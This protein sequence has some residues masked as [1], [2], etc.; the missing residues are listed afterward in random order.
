MGVSGK[1]RA[2][3][4]PIEAASGA[5][6]PMEA[7]EVPAHPEHA[8]AA[9][10]ADTDLPMSNRVGRPRGIPKTGG[11]KKGVKNR[12]TRQ[13]KELAL[14]YGKR[15]FTRLAKLLKSDDDKIVLAA[16]REI[17]D[18]AYGRPQVFNEITGPGGSPL[19]KT[20]ADE[21]DIARRVA[22]LLTRGLAPK[23]VP[24]MPDIDDGK[25]APPH[26]AGQT[27]SA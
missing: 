6:K 26:R 27:Q 16:S 8:S 1:Q 5:S 12:I 21:R 7:S 11:R 14:P 20:P 19:I 22:F 13:I 9:S 4:R 10:Q 3:R 2:N 17:L 23:A 24:A 18:R 25:N 15:A